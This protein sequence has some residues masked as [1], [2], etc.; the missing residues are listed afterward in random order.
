MS[1]AARTATHRSAPNV[2]FFAT[3]VID[4]FAPEAGIDAIEVLE[5]SGVI[6]HFP[7]RQTCCGQPAYTTGSSG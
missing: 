6:V 1:A 5:R 7:L 4:M 3:C 2:Y